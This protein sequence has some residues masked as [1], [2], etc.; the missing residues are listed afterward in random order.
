MEEIIHENAFAEKSNYQ[1][2]TQL[3]FGNTQQQ[4]FCVDVLYCHLYPGG[5]VPVLENAQ[6]VI[7][8]PTKRQVANTAFKEI[9]FLTSM[10]TK[11]LIK[12]F[13]FFAFLIFA[14]SG[15]GFLF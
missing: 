11:L 14:K 5:H 1:G 13:N 3:E 9:I 2:L 7:I 12:A 6:E 10:F 8:I 4:C 15:V